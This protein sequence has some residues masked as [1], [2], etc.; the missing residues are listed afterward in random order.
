[1]LFLVYVSVYKDVVIVSVSF[2]SFLFFFLHSSATSLLEAQLL[3]GC[4][5][6][7]LFR[8]A[9]EQR[10]AH[11]YGDTCITRDQPVPASSPLDA[12]SPVLCLTVGAAGESEPASKPSVQIP[13]LSQQC[14]TADVGDHQ[15]SDF[16]DTNS[17]CQPDQTTAS[18]GPDLARHVQMT[19]L[20]LPHRRPGPRRAKPDLRR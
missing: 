13:S 8:L 2:L 4:H 17:A 18:C 20:S 12:R 1:M 3:T 19:S 10:Y 9:E 14:Q 5:S 15:S 16:H 6:E 11:E 7:A